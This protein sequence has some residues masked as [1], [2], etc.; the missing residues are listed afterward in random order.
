M[1]INRTA[2]LLGAA[3]LAVTDLALSGATDAAG[4]SASGAAALVSLSAADGLSVTELG[5]RVGLSQ[6]AAARM[7]DSLE[8]SQLAARHSGVGRTV[9]VK[10]TTAGRRV[11]RDLLAA[12]SAPLTDVLAVLDDDEQE[13][14]TWLLTK[15]LT[16]LYGEVGN[17]QLLCRMCDRASCL[18]NAECPVGQAERDS[19]R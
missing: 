15:M 4:V 10:P 17:A 18:H 3:A 6:S 5:R 9:I 11:A 16:R 2:N 12:R 8:A 1:H 19:Q 7:V 13:T 14:L